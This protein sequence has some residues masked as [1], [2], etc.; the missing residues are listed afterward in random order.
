MD[1]TAPPPSN[2][3]PVPIPIPDASNPKPIAETKEEQSPAIAVLSKDPDALD[4]GGGISFLTGSKTAG[5][6]YGYASLK[7]KRASMEDYMETTISE[8]DGQMVA[9]FGVFDG[10]GGSRTAEYL[11]NTLFKNLSAHPGFMKDTKTAI[12]EA[13]KQTDDDYLNGENPQQRDA[14]STASTVVIIGDKILVANVGDSR[15]VA[16]RAGTG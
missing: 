9:F 3:P 11:K 14:G 13:F 4:S 10:H 15:V 8:V 5:F 6:S 2:Q 1:A 16:S 7:G 12:V